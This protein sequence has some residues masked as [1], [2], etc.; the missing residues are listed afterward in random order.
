MKLGVK[1][2]AGL[3]IFVEGQ[4]DNFSLLS[5]EQFPYLYLELPDV[6][7]Q[8]NQACKHPLPLMST[9][10]HFQFFDDHIDIVAGLNGFIIFGVYSMCILLEK[11]DI[12]NK[13]LLL[14]LGLIDH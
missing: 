1:F 13:G 6:S 4:V 11:V 5:D 3:D 12:A 10:D 7:I 9:A 8:F 2:A 14:E